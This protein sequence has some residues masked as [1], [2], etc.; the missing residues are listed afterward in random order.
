MAAAVPAGPVVVRRRPWRYWM[1]RGLW[2]GVDLIFP[3]RCAGCRAPGARLCA[4]CQSG[5]TRLAPPWCNHCGLPLRQPGLCGA[6][7][8]DP[9]RLEPLAGLRAAGVFEGALQSALHQLKYQRD[10]I[11]ADTLGEALAAAPLW[12][13][14]PDG[15]IVPVPLSTERLRERGYNQAGLLAR[16]VAEARGLPLRP[17]AARRVR[18]TRSQV[19]LSVAQRH[20]NVRG[21]FAGQA[22]SVAG[23]TVL[24]VDDVCTT[25]ATLAACAAALSD[26]GASAVWGIALA[27]ARG[28]AGPP[29]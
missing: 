29:P 19:G 13:D 28:G 18:H 11:L 16:A 27:R 7:Q 2:A 12:A 14:V 21:A 9:Q 3:P 25:G 1:R 8:A 23:R 4:A 6:C 10:A 15:V 24:L 20:A 5:L 26:A 17:E 22:R